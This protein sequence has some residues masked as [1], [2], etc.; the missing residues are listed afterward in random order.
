MDTLPNDI[1]RQWPELIRVSAWLRQRLIDIEYAD[2]LD[3]FNRCVREQTTVSLHMIFA[4]IEQR[5]DNR[6]KRVHVAIV[7]S[8]VLY[9]EYIRFRRRPPR[10]VTRGD[11]KVIRDV[12]SRAAACMSDGRFKNICYNAIRD[13]RIDVITHIYRKYRNLF[14]DAMIANAAGTHG[15]PAMIDYLIANTTMMF[16][17]LDI[18]IKM[19]ELG[20]FEQYCAVNWPLNAVKSALYFNVVGRAGNIQ[21]IEHVLNCFNNAQYDYPYRYISAGAYERGHNDIAITY[22][23]QRLSLRTITATENFEQ[24]E[25]AIKTMMGA[26]AS[27]QR[28]VDE[29]VP[30]DVLA[31]ARLHM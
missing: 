5:G 11:I 20:R 30:E 24:V 28:L 26:G 3:I 6:Y 14:S 17:V 10:Y 7:S 8:R 16:R 15:T 31:I 4:L 21:L 1:L 22:T 2:L 19:I 12:L 23:C 25:R 18:G 9:T 27:Y 29:G 13:N